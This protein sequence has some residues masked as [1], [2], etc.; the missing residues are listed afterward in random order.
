M[1]KP[2]EA[3]M[4]AAESIDNVF[5]D[6]EPT[7]Y[8][9]SKA[10][11]E[12]IAELIDAEYAPAI[13]TLRHYEN[14]DNWILVFNNQATIKPD[15]PFLNYYIGQPIH[16]RHGKGWEPARYTLEKLGIPLEEND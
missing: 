9:I 12:L 6:S 14:E 1:T 15:L 11:R 13:E 5:Y 10:Q 7:P 2:S 4:R 16:D 8:A 3:A